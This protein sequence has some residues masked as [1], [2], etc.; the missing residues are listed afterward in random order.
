[1]FL[2]RASKVIKLIMDGRGEEALIFLMDDLLENP[3]DAEV[4]DLMGF[5]YGEMGEWESALECY[6]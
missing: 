6:L 3:Y 1:M 2:D 4:W 5:V